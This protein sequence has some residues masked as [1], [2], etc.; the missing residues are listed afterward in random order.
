[1]LAGTCLQES[2]SA[3]VDPG[4]RLRSVVDEHGASVPR[5]DVLA[6]ERTLL[7]EARTGFRTFR[8]SLH[9]LR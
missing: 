1:M 5:G 9:D 3:G 6:R 2:A 4:S 7:L 8:V